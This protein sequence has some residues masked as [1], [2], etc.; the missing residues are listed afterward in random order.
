MDNR[1]YGMVSI[2]IPVYNVEPYLKECV[3]SLVAQ[4]YKNIELIF[5]DDGSTDESSK[6]ID[7]YAARDNRIKVIHKTNGGQASARNVGLDNATGDYY[8]FVDSDDFVTEDYVSFMIKAL[9]DNDAD[10]VFCNFSSSYADDVVPSSRLAQHTQRRSFD[11][12]EYLHCFYQFTGA[13][14]YV[15]NKIYKKKVFDNLRY[16]ERIKCEDAELMLYII[17]NCDSIYFIPDVLYYYRRRCS[18][19]IISTKKEEL[20]YADMGWLEEHMEA[21]K[22]SGRKHLHDM[23]LKAYLHKIYIGL[24]YCDKDTRKLVKEKMRIGIKSLLHSKEFGP[25]IKIKYMIAAS[26]PNAYGR[27]YEIKHRNKAKF[28]G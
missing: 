12:G 6:I 7:E 4:T 1:D 19:T 8:M 25:A 2:I 3:D 15:W 26:F 11:K 23:A 17:D 5:V 28:W 9:C 18:G 24:M 14:T 22:L 16:K 20:L 13:Y 10:M 27:W 21:L